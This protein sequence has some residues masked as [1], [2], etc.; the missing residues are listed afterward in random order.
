MFSRRFSFWLGNSSSEN[1]LGTFAKLNENLSLQWCKKI[2]S[3]GGQEN[4]RLSCEN[5]AFH[6]L[7]IEIAKGF[8][9]KLAT[10]FPD[11]IFRKFNKRVSNAI[12]QL[13][14]K[15]LKQF[16][17]LNLFY[18]NLVFIVSSHNEPSLNELTVQCT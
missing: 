3:N 2:C 11:E 10:S 1:S 6:K 8:F 15:A 13:L 17:Y 4:F 18:V 7:L 5:G 14:M 16:L 9:F 12:P